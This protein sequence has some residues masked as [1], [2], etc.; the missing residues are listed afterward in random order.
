MK[1]FIEALKNGE[2]F[3]FLTDDKTYSELSKREILGI[4]QELMYAIEESGLLKS[5]I[6]DVYNTAAENLTERYDYEFEEE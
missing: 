5:D 2:G 3:S 6:Q 4:A 1:Q